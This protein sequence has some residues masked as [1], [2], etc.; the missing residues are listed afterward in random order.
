M[1]KNRR[2]LILQGYNLIENG[3]AMLE[4]A[5]EEEQEAYDNLP[6]SIQEGDRGCAMEEYIDALETVVGYLEDAISDLEDIDL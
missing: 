2:Q 5:L 6:E 3:K 1:N 4:T